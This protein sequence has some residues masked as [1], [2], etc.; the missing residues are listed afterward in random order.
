MWLLDYRIEKNKSALYSYWYCYLNTNNLIRF[1]LHSTDR[2]SLL[3]D[4]FLNKFNQLQNTVTTYITYNAGLITILYLQRNTYL[5]Y[6]IKWFTFAGN[7]VDWIHSLQKIQLKYQLLT[8][9]PIR[10]FTTR[11]TFSYLRYFQ[12][13]NKIHYIAYRAI[14]RRLC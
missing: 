7:T 2:L 5:I 1:Y 4:V 12:L 11:E 6:N 9:L 14:H 13:V 3:S 8:L 10:L